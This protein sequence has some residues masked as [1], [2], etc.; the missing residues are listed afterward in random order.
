[1]G[2]RMTQLPFDDNLDISVFSSVFDN[3]TNSYKFYW[4]L[5]FLDELSLNS[6]SSEPVS[7]LKLFKTM[8]IRSWHTVFDFKLSLGKGDFIEKFIKEIAE[9]HSNEL[10]VSFLDKNILLA[11]LD[12]LDKEV[13]KDYLDLLKKNVVYRFLTPF[14]NFTGKDINLENIKNNSHKN[15]KVLYILEDNEI[16]IKTNWQSYLIR[17][18]NILEKW[19]EYHL[20]QYL[21]KKN[22]NSPAIP[23]KIFFSGKR[24][25]IEPKKIELCKKVF[26]NSKFDFK[27]IYTNQVLIDENIET[28]HFLPWSFVAHN[29]IWNLIPT[30]KEINLKKSDYLPDIMNK[31]QTMLDEF[32]EFQYYIYLEALNKKN[33]NILDEY[34]S[35][36]INI[37]NRMNESEFSEI[38]KNTILPLYQ[39][40]K[41]QGFRVWQ[42]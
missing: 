27:D 19:A 22:P 36:K 28:D 42:T 8:I 31:N 40:A 16:I 38:L 23:N 41:N 29:D 3:K 20:I 35:I 9:L 5:S 26:F 15:S 1:M 33:K 17:N 13:Y 25:N 24:T 21:Q 30:S 2:L 10:S 37:E 18:R 12:S 14:C 32:C 7:F 34:L 11:K 6:K 39:T 4:F